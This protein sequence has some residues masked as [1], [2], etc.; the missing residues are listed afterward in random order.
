MLGA[1]DR[2]RPMRHRNSA[3]RNSSNQAREA[4]PLADQQSVPTAGS[5][6]DAVT[7]APAVCRSCGAAPREGARFCDACGSKLVASA[8]AAEYQQVTA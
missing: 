6:E 7:A 1:S 4:I 3:C 5:G 8:L 2:A